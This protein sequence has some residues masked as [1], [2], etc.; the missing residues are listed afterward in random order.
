LGRLPN[1]AEIGRRIRVVRR[2]W[3]LS[4]REFAKKIGVSQPAVSR[5]ER[6]IDTPDLTS[7]VHLEQRLSLLVAHHGFQHLYATDNIIDQALAGFHVPLRG[8][9]ESRRWCRPEEIEKDSRELIVLPPRLA[10]SVVSS[11]P[12]GQFALESQ[13]QAMIDTY[14]L[15]SILLCE[16]VKG[17]L[18][19]GARVIVHRFRED[20]LVEQSCREYRVVDGQ[21]WLVAR[22]THPAFLQPIKVKR[23]LRI[24]DGDVVA[25]VFG[26][27]IPEPN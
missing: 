5:W 21:S 25:R 8:T 23:D 15:G 16:P 19:H 18:K 20:G 24:E 14:P 22:S 3:R 9:V 10:G 13:D 4:Q 6:G 1:Q 17:K 26:A 12:N 11:L 2:S 7:L 27:Y